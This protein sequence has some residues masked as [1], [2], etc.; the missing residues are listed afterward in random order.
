[1]NLIRY[2]EKFFDEIEIATYR[3]K[4]TSVDI[5]LNQV[6]LSSTSDRTITVI[7]GI[8]DKRVGIYI[9]DSN[10]ENEIKRG[11]EMA[12]KS[13]RMN[14][15]DERWVSL[16]GEQKYANVKIEVSDELKNLSPDIL[17]NMANEAIKEIKT[18]DENAMVAGG[19]AGS[20]WSE[21]RIMNSRGVDVLQEFG[22]TFFYLYAIGRKDGVVTPGIMEF[23][24]R[25]DTNISTDSVVNSILERLK[26]AYRVVKTED[27]TNDVMLEPLALAELIYFA[28]LPA[29]NGEKKV[30]GTSPLANMVNEKILHEKINM[31]DDPWHP[32]STSPVIADDEGV[33]SRK[34]VMFQNGVF[35][36]F[37]WDNYWGN[38][39][40]EGSTGNGI[41]S[42]VTGGI[43]IGAHNLVIE[44]GNISREDLL[45]DMKNGLIVSGF[46][47]AH[48]SNPDTGDFSVVANPAFRVEYGKIVGS[49][50]FMM[51][52]NIYNLLKNVKDISSTQKNIVMMGNGTMPDILFENVKIA[53]VSK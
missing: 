12:S 6:S 42:L 13:A 26:Y 38:V 11:I 8:K 28:L 2:G 16:P 49:T 40:G 43:S 53:P 23:D 45:S 5:E 24:V 46:Q 35:K 9:V 21:N 41:R 32:L 36:G 10:D 1:M 34:N 7:R 18:R 20:F 30:K 33:A 47:G 31:V 19:A 50:V 27:G 3:K 44:A 37:L 48:S 29:L 22:G 39:S 4:E 52:G 51:S 17:V 14:E 25:R 15:P